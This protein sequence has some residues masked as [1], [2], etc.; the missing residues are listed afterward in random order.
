VNRS[1]YST[2][3]GLPVELIGVL[4]YAFIF[5]VATIYGDNADTPII[6]LIASVGGLGFALYLTYVEK[7]V[8]DAWCTLC[9]TSLGLV[10]ARNWQQLLGDT[11]EHWTASHLATTV[12]RPDSSAYRSTHPSICLDFSFTNGLRPK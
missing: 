8:L 7:F 2:V 1:T 11:S 4:G 12:S 9:L 3:L 5:A 6:L 10:S